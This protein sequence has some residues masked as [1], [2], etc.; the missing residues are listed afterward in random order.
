MKHILLLVT[1]CISIIFH[2]LSQNSDSIHTGKVI[3]SFSYGVDEIT[4][5]IDETSGC[6]RKS[7]PHSV[8]VFIP[9]ESVELVF[10]QN[11]QLVE[12]HKQ[13]QVATAYAPINCITQNNGCD[14]GLCIITNTNNKLIVEYSFENEKLYFSA[15]VNHNNSITS[16]ITIYKHNGLNQKVFESNFVEKRNEEY[17]KIHSKDAILSASQNILIQD[18]T[19]LM[20][21]EESLFEKFIEQLK[22]SQAPFEN[23]DLIANNYY[24]LA[25]LKTVNRA[26]SQ[27]SDT[28]NCSPIPYYFAEN[29]PFICQE[30]FNFNIQ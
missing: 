26:I 21:N 1:C 22:N 3:G 30:D 11:S 7:V 4:A 17:Y 23:I 29:S 20:L 10:I 9:Q 12:V 15:Y 25:I 14:S 27:N 6:L 16:S 18:S 28:C 5:I 2:T 19:A 24:H 13:N 8:G